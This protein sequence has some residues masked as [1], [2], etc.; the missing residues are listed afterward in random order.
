MSCLLYADDLEILDI[1]Q[2][3]LQ[4]KL[5][6]FNH[7]C[8]ANKLKVNMIKTKIITFGKKSKPYK[9]QLGN[10]RVERLSFYKYLCMTFTS[11]L[12]W[13]LHKELVETR[14]LA[15]IGGLVRYKK[16]YGGPSWTPL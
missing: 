6:T 13:T 9:W 15:M 14:A 16:T 5:I 4:R 10:T 3:G 11:K 2:V 8:E 7:Y 1:T 12:S